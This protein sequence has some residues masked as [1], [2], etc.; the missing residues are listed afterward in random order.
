MTQ[1]GDDLS[2]IKSDLVTVKSEM[3]TKPE[4]KKLETRVEIL[5]AG[6]VGNE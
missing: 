3:V 5:E 6:G 1:F 4:V 2:E